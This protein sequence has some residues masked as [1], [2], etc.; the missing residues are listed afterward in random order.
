MLD[1]HA[2][3]FVEDGSNALDHR[4]FAEDV[5]DIG[6]LEPDFAP[7]LCASA[8]SEVRPGKA[9][10]T[11]VPQELKMMPMARSKPEP[12]ASRM[13]IVAIPQAM[14]SM[15]SAVRRRLCCIAPRASFNRSPVITPP[16]ELLLAP[17]RNP[18][19]HLRF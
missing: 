9:P 10:I 19:D 13:T 11:S 4:D 5:I 18:L 8:C 7:R 16:G 12:N 1:G 6:D 3:S 17:V 14:P 2:I 15:V